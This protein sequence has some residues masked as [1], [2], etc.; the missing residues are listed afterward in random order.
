[1]KDKSIFRFVS[2]RFVS[3]RFVL[4]CFVL[5][6]F[7]L[8]CF[9]LFCFVLFCF[10]LFCFVLFCFVLF[11]FVLFCFVL[12]CF[13]LFCF[14]LFWCFIRCYIRCFYVIFIIIFFYLE[15]FYAEMTRRTKE[16]NDQTTKKIEQ[17]ELTIQKLGNNPFLF[18]PFSL[19][20][21]KYSR[22]T[23]ERLVVKSPEKSLP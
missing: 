5:F 17:L 21:I 7:V 12:F 6:C 23:L 11:C 13:V 2:F 18:Y 20:S 15:R 1:M 4:F 9:V 10:V 8:F 22:I 14:V 3:F 19:F 16:Q